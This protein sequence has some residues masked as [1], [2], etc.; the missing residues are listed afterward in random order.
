MAGAAAAHENPRSS[1]CI[2]GFI[3][4]KSLMRSAALAEAVLGLGV[5]AL[6]AFI[7]V[8]SSALPVS[9]AYAKVGSQVIPYLVAAGLIVLGLLFAAMSLRPRAADAAPTTAEPA[10]WQAL[11][12][13]SVGLVAQMLLLVPAGF[14]IASAIL[15]YCVAFGFGS[16]RYLRDGAIAILLAVVVYVGF[17]RGLDLQ[18]PAGV[19][20]GVL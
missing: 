12:V 8:E 17:T 9:P 1:A 4:L 15:F 3:R 14:V 5:A 2:C 6:G 20:A 7:A 19:L 18:L 11:A 10:D 16:R 13:I